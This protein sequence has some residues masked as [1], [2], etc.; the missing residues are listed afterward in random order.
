MKNKP[1]INLTSN[2][3]KQLNHILSI[4]L[5]ADKELNGKYNKGLDKLACKI[6]DQLEE[7]DNNTKAN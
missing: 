2:E 1:S 6:L 7:Y 3:W 5:G 4:V